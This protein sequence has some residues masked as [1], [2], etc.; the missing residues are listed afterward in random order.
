MPNNKSTSEIEKLVSSVKIALLDPFGHAIDGLKYK[1]LQGEKIVARGITDGHGRV[2]QFASELGKELSIQVEHFTTGAMTQIHQL[3]PWNEKMSLK[4]V[5]GKVKYKT[6]FSADK[7]APG[8]YK[9]KTHVVVR[10]DTLSGIAAKNSTT[11][12]A[13]ATL[14]NIPLESTLHIAQVLKL[15]SAQPVAAVAE[16]PAAAPGPAPT[17]APAKTTKSSAASPTVPEAEPTATVTP[18]PRPTSGP[19]PSNVPPPAQL[20]DGRGE[21]G[22][23]KTT[24]ALQCN[25]QSCIK[26]GDKGFLIEELNVRLMGFGNT[27]SSPTAWNEF[28]AKTEN[29]V[30]QFQRD[31]MGVPETGK[32]CGGF[33][34]ALDDFCSKY[35]VRLDRM[36]CPCG[37]CNGFG[38]NQKDSALAGVFTDALRTKPRKG[39]E[40]PGMHRALLW[41]FRASLFYAHEKDKT[42]TF[43][44]LRVSSGYR[45]WYDNAGFLNGRANSKTK[46]NS[47]N[48]MGNALD[49][50]WTEGKSTIRCTGAS[51]DKLREKIFVKRLGAQLGWE[52]ANTASL[53]TAEDGATNWVHLDVRELEPQYKDMRYYAVTQ[54]GVD[55]DSMLEIA[56]REGRLTLV[57]CG[58]VRPTAT[59]KPAAEPAD[60]SQRK[61]VASLSTSKK[62][63][64]FIK[65]WE[66]LSL[67]PYD[68]SKGYCTIGWGRLIANKKCSDLSNDQNFKPYKNGIDKAKADALLELDIKD[69]ESKV[70]AAIQVPILQQEY[71]ALVS[72]IFNLGGFKNCPKLLSKINTKDYSGCCDEFADITNSGNTGLVKRRKAEMAIFRNN[73]YDSTH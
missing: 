1:I 12:Q 33:L 73:S 66:K 60:T 25:Q 59:N 69:A 49:L 32:V 38:S 7:G 22:T 68:D 11:A 10:G 23:P 28:T 3:T 67:Q 16:A 72:L 43:K 17:P 29:A 27:T 13:I 61:P 51:V 34:Q 18:P 20:A 53:E 19:V 9:R 6:Q 30:K 70:K 40:Y 5:S 37:K 58:G 42:L 39:V 4:L 31:Y 46:R 50:Q 21:N 64:E 8:D 35:P 71:D 55:G 54:S 65:G 2:Q 48:H 45:C 41:A 36:K 15:P 52:K 63:I 47:T 24:V 56:R 14:N 44:F 26:L 62:C 57:A